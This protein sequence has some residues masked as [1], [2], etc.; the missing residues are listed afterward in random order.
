MFSIVF[1]DLSLTVTIFIIDV[2]I[3]IVVISYDYNSKKNY[4]YSD[5]YDRINNYS[6]NENYQG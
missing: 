3:S 5:Y 1:Y 6:T 4:I 2:R